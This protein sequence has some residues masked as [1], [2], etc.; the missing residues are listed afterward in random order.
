M[1]RQD[2]IDEKGREDKRGEEKRREE[3]R[4]EDKRTGGKIREYNEKTE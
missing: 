4:R 3:Q 1:V 2:E